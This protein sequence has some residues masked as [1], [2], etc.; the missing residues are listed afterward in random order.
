M[1]AMKRVENKERVFYYDNL[2]AGLIFL[3]V[4]G[5]FLLIICAIR[6]NAYLLFSYAIV[7]FRVWRIL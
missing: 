1:T 6:K 3:V 5:H 4:L 7:R 2:R